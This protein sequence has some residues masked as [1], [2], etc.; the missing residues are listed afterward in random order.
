MT[1]TPKLFDSQGR[2]VFLGELVGKGGEGSV[3]RIEGEDGL[4][5]KLYHQRP[6]PVDM[7]AKIRA[8]VAMR[9]PE[10]DSISAWP[11]S[12]VHDPRSR[13]VLGLIMP[14][15]VDSHHLHDL[16]GT[17]NR[18]R[19]F[20]EARWHHLLLAARN[21]AAA[22]ESLHSAGIIVGDV[23][24]GNL[25]VDQN[26]CVRFIDCDSFQFESNGQVFPCPVG[27]PHFTPPELQSQK[28]RAVERTQNH[29]AFGLAI[30]IFHLLF[31]GRHPFAG[32][33]LGDKE[34]TIETAIA[35]RRFAF[36]RNRDETQVDPPPASLLLNDLPNPM[37][38]MFERAFRSNGD[39]ELRPAARQWVDQLEM[40]IKQRNI[41]SS[42][43]T[44]VYFNQL[45]NCPWCRIEDTGGPTF[46]FAAGGL[47]MVSTGRLEA[48]DRKI[49]QLQIPEFIDLSPG[50]LKLPSVLK[51]K[52]LAK[53]P[54]ATACDVAAIGMV[55]A[56]SICL[57]GIKWLP[58]LGIGAV[59]S[60]ASGAYLNFSDKGRE[61][62][63]RGKNLLETLEQYQEQLAKKAR[64]IMAKH[65]NRKR[66]FNS[67]IEDLK[68]AYEIYQ[69]EENQL[70]DVLAI[71]R[72]A[73]LNRF[74][75]G[76]LLQDNVANVSGMNFSML[77]VLESYGVE[78]ALDVDSL[79][80]MGVPMLNPA[81]TL[82]L[83][84]WR[85]QVAGSFKF[86]PEHGISFEDAKLAGEAALNRFKIAQARKVVIGGTQ[87]KDLA[88][89]GKAE[90]D[91]DLIRFNE[92]ADKG[93]LIA[94]QLRDFQSGRRVLERE[95][96][97]HPTVTA[98]VAIGIPL[99]GYVLRLIFV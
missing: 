97:R 48:L 88:I 99:V 51:P 87:L 76:H 52:K 26:M 6:M 13:D 7:L 2:E 93:R 15:V 77:S 61:Q 35:E 11:R 80:L 22:F 49:Q 74:L 84:S 94:N 81:L 63:Q 24:Q 78:S 92:M 64:L 43:S 72:T 30:V 96:N 42:D 10:L 85:E 50:Q 23:N 1:N 34:L 25:L 19:H 17:A 66:Q 98:T 65:Q 31:V 71:Q 29:D 58:A 70:Q 4:V 89:V 62:R 36:S 69:S 28:L 44:H 33:F 21:V 40:L 16:Y 83:L 90:V 60:L 56:A 47:S 67:A 39:Q 45:R 38:D 9:T 73:Q 27:T 20:P 18:R 79:K 95:L 54:P 41:C 82:E 3:Y 57:L 14:K 86:K 68:K 12:L 91:R 5:A 46:F 59:A 32:R 55:V 37:A 75:A 53:S 8:M